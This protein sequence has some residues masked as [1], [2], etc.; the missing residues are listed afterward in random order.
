[1]NGQHTSHASVQSNP[2]RGSTK[3]CP[4]LQASS[5][6]LGPLRP[7]ARITKWNRTSSHWSTASFLFPNRCPP[8]KDDTGVGRLRTMVY[9]IDPRGCSGQG[10]ATQ[11]GCTPAP[12][13]SL[14]LEEVCRSATWPLGRPT[15][16]ARSGDT[17]VR[18]SKAPPE[19]MLK[20]E[21]HLELGSAV[22]QGLSVCQSSGLLKREWPLAAGVDPHAGLLFSVPSFQ[23]ALEF[24]QVNPA[25][26]G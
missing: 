21:R 15:P 22:L 7:P 19:N 9:G 5:S 20:Q 18:L 26:L 17:S 23:L 24:V 25:S 3:P 1:M 14:E 4:L 2:Q 12:Q 8:R 16:K 11:K 10:L 13:G 6:A